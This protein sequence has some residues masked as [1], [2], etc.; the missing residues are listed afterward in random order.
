MLRFAAGGQVLGYLYN[1]RL[2][3][4][5]FTYQSGFDYAG[6]T[7]AVGPHAKPGLTCHYAA[8]VRAQR[9]GVVAYD[10]LAGRDRYKTSLTRAA[11]RLYWLDVAPRYSGQGLT[12]WLHE[13]ATGRR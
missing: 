2:R 11:T 1:L 9:D 7:A 10:F 3:G 13:L 8:I 4:C 5:E 6:C 12:L